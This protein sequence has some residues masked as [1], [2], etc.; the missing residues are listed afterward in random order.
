MRVK[1]S[2]WLLGCHQSTDIISTIKTLLL[3]VVSESVIR[4]AV[5]AAA[6]KQL[7]WQGAVFHATAAEGGWHVWPE[8]PG[9]PVWLRVQRGGL[10]LTR[11][12]RGPLAVARK[13]SARQI[14]VDV[15]AIPLR[16]S[17]S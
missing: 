6:M 4:P 11:T 9:G 16:D 12:G 1:C 17:T 10:P 14:L 13:L 15:P 2:E 3:S 7:A 8:G 5:E